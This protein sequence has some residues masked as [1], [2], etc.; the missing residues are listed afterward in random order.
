MGIKVKEKRED[1]GVLV[2][3]GEGLGVLAAY[4]MVFYFLWEGL[5]VHVGAK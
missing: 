4:C 3:I 1:K 2:S 5:L